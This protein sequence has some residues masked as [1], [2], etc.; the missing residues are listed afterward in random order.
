[1]LFGKCRFTSSSPTSMNLA[2]NQYSKQQ[3][4][5]VHSAKFKQ[6]RIVSSLLNITTPRVIY[7]KYASWFLDVVVV[8]ILRV[9]TSVFYFPV[10]HSR[11][12]KN[13][14]YSRGCKNDFYFL[15]THFLIAF[16]CALCSSIKPKKIVFRVHTINVG[17]EG[18]GRVPLSYSSRIC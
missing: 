5:Q 1:M 13:C 12:Y 2:A 10:K 11:P 18:G 7:E 4:N 6:A 9:W 17:G 14:G 15:F 8:L 16:L 3:T